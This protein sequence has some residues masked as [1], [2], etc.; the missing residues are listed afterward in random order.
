MRVT[1]VVG[2]VSVESSCDLDG[3]EIYKVSCMPLK[4]CYVRVPVY[5]VAV[6][7]EMVISGEL[8]RQAVGKPKISGTWRTYGAWRA[9]GNWGKTRM[10]L[11]RR[12]RRP[13]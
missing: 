4:P 3:L 10:C 6:A 5:L 8:P 9:I 2:S 7:V 12:T 1:G 11:P 13:R